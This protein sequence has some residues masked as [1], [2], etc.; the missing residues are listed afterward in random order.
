MGL[1]LADSGGAGHQTGP[2]RSANDAY[3]V[4]LKSAECDPP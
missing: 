4:K 1:D 2:S 3:F